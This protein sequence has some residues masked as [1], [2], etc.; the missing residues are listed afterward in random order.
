HNQNRK[1]QAR[2]ELMK[3]RSVCR[4][5]LGFPESHW[6]SIAE[7]TN[8]SR[9]WRDA[10]CRYIRA[11]VGPVRHN[12]ARAGCVLPPSEEVAQRRSMR[13]DRVVVLR[14]DASETDGLPHKHRDAFGLHLLHDFG[15]IAF[16][17]PYTDTQL[18]GD[19]VTGEA[20]RDK[21]EDFDLSRCQAREIPAEGLLRLLQ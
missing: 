7:R 21:V 1:I 11:E 5:V 15:A 8:A 10:P 16:D 20:F 19:G 13:H 14:V 17:R 9:L 12:L 3:G 2:S 4:A 18:G 6:T